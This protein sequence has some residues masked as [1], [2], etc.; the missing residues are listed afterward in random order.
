MEI[1][2]NL[3]ECTREEALAYLR[4]FLDA[5]RKGRANYPGSA[6]D[7]HLLETGH[8]LAFN[9]CGTTPSGPDRPQVA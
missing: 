6:S 5:H 7:L 4:G 1:T 2:M 8:R 3:R 9:C